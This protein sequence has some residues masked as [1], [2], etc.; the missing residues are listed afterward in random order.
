MFFAGAVAAALAIAFHGDGYAAHG[1]YVI[2]FCI[3]DAAIARDIPTQETQRHRRRLRAASPVIKTNSST[4]NG[5]QRVEVWITSAISRHFRASL[6]SLS[7]P[8]TTTGDFHEE[9][10]RLIG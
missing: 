1:N 5:G 4:P 9:N 10:H 3:R 6:L 7:Y 2:E 8:P